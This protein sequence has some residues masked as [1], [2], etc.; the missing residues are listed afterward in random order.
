[1]KKTMLITA[2]LLFT[3]STHAQLRNRVF[4]DPNFPRVSGIAT[5]SN[6]VYLDVEGTPYITEDF[7]PAKINNSKK[8][9]HVRYDAYADLMEVKEEDGE[10]TLLDKN[11]EYIVK[12][13]DGSHKIYQT[14]T[15]EDGQRGFA[16]SKWIDADKNSL[17]LREKIT[18]SPY[19]PVRNGYQP[20]QA[21]FYSEVEY[22]YYI[23][24]AKNASVVKLKSRKKPFFATFEGKEKEVAKFVRNKN[25]EIKKDEDLRQIMLFYFLSKDPLSV[26]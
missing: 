25:L 14:V 23:K 22:A 15:Y 9:Y 8:I 24:D 26:R 18:F 5:S 13:N 7:V 16:I 19:I 3:F 21:P 1:M 10:L 6:I 20:A 2:I 11:R 12:L 17:Y 4:N